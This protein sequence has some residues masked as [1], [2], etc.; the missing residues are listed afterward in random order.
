MFIVP[1][2]LTLARFG[3]AE[4]KPGIFNQVAL[5]P[6]KPRV[7]NLAFQAINITLLTE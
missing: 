1:R 6:S 7:V 2:Y 3:R 5:R 4:L